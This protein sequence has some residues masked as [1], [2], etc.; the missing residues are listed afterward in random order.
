MKN[1]ICYKVI[2]FP[3]IHLSILEGGKTHLRIRNPAQRVWTCQLVLSTGLMLERCCH[4]RELV[5]CQA[6]LFLSQVGMRR[7][8]NGRKKLYQAP[9]TI[10]SHSPSLCKVE[11]LVFAFSAGWAPCPKALSCFPPPLPPPFLPFLPFH[12]LSNRGGNWVSF[13][14]HSV[15]FKLSFYLLYI[16]QMLNTWSCLV[17]KKALRIWNRPAWWQGLEFKPWCLS[18]VC[19]K[20]LPL[21]PVKS[22]KFWVL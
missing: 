7:F 8:S 2:F 19:A 21:L 22:R 12:G 20:S 3:Q 6:W 17:L 5:I 11:G 9:D 4:H 1:L 10:K 15:F 16:W 14:C 18:W 13:V